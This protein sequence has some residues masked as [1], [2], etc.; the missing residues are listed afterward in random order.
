MTFYQLLDFLIHWKINYELLES[1]YDLKE[2]LWP[3][4]MVITVVHE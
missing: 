3:T 1:P 4:T 2:G